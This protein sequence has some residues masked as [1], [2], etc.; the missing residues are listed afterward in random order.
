MDELDL[1]SFIMVLINHQKEHF[2]L[3]SAFQ[4]LRARARV[5][6]ENVF[7]S[8]ARFSSNVSFSNVFVVSALISSHLFRFVRRRFFAWFSSCQVQTTPVELQLVTAQSRPLP[9]LSFVFRL[10]RSGFLSFCSHTH[11]LGCSPR[12]NCVCH[13][14]ASSSCFLTCLPFFS[15]TFRFLKSTVLNFK[16]THTHPHTCAFRRCPGSFICSFS[17]SRSQFSEERCVNLFSS[18]TCIG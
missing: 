5:G 9:L 4:I 11:T 16:S 17:S 8:W 14:S 13:H 10:I 3:F 12:I 15:F 1:T 6:V 2:F 7:F 18:S